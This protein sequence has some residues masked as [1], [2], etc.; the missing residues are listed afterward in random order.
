MAAIQLWACIKLLNGTEMGREAADC[1][2]SCD[3]W[4]KV[5]AASLI[6]AIIY[7]IA[8]GKWMAL[9]IQVLLRGGFLYIVQKYMEELKGGSY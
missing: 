2:K 9:A 6:L 5:T 4:R 3:N 1:L 7:G 8:Q